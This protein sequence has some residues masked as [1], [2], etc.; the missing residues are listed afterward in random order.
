MT[1][2]LCLIVLRIIIYITDI[3]ELRKA[4]LNGKNV[5]VPQYL[6]CQNSSGELG[7]CLHGKVDITFTC[8]CTCI[9]GS[10]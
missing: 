10:T 9:V 1:L 4:R 2:V 7:M 6:T 5:S 3:W 8:M